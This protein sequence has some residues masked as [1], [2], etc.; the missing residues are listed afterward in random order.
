M[1]MLSPGAVSALASLLRSVKHKTTAQQEVSR[2]SLLL[3]EQVAFGY[4]LVLV[5]SNADPLHLVFNTVALADWEGIPEVMI[6]LTEYES[7][8]RF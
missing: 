4:M 2:R 1:L 3:S 8:L 7:E 5:P 6:D